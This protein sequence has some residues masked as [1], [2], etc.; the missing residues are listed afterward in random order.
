MTV[1]FGRVQPVCGIDLEIELK[2]GHCCT[3]RV[4]GHPLMS[5]PEATDGDR[6]CSVE[7]TDIPVLADKRYRN[8]EC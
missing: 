7:G 8:Q 6:H 3:S 5:G 1:G 2:L 4:T